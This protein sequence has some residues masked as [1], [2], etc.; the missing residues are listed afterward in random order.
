MVKVAIVLSLMG[1][2]AWANDDGE[3]RRTGVVL[4]VGRIDSSTVE[5][6][7]L[8]VVVYGQGERH[9][10]SGAWAKL[11]TVRGYIKAMRRRSLILSL[12]RYGWPES[13]TLERIQSLVLVGDRETGMWIEKNKDKRVAQKLMSGTIMGSFVGFVGGM[14]AFSS[15]DKDCPD[16][17]KSGEFLILGCGVGEAIALGSLGYTVGVAIGVSRVDPYD[18]FIP[19]LIGSVAGFIAAAPIIILNPL[20]ILAFPFIPPVIATSASERWRK[21][22]EPPRFSLGL[23]PNRRGGLLTVATLRF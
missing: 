7:A 8:V 23:A 4:E 18:R 6:G 13:I 14:V 22:P 17:D 15:A 10:T 21:P 1:A 9:P 2:A 12:E 20:G 16:A 19:T 3:S 5:V 11:D